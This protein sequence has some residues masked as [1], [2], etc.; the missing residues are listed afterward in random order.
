METCANPSC[1]GIPKRGRYCSNPCY[2]DHMADI[3]DAAMPETRNRNYDA[4]PMPKN[5]AMAN[6]FLTG[7][8]LES[9]DDLIEEMFGRKT[10]G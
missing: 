1:D 4:K 7:R 10:D 3:A 8:G 9:V 2:H 5:Q 6:A